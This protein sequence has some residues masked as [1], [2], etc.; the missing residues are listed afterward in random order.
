MLA[1][2]QITKIQKAVTEENDERIPLTFGA[3]ADPGRY[4][5]FKLLV[6]REVFMDLRKYSR[7]LG[8]RRDK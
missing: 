3:L 5:I 6:K 7:R 2:E 1:K 8:S 4:R